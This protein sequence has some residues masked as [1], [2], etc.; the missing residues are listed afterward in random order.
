MQ[1][2]KKKKQIVPN[3][4]TV[5]KADITLYV[6]TCKIIKKYEIFTNLVYVQKT[7]PKNS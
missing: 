1:D 4:W 3:Y 2:Q 6:Y 5:E 7:K